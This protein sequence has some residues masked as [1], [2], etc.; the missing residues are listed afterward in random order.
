MED[1]FDVELTYRFMD[2]NFS[3]ETFPDTYSIHMYTLERNSIQHPVASKKGGVFQHGR[4]LEEG[5]HGTLFW[6]GSEVIV[7]RLSLLIRY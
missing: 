2:P 1:L 3:L 5:L 6:L 4:M 7:E